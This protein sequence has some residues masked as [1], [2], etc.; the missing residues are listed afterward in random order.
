MRSTVFCKKSYTF[1]GEERSSFTQ[2]KAYP[3]QV[4]QSNHVNGFAII[5]DLGQTHW[6]RE[7]GHPEF[8]EYFE[9][10]N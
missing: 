4:T 7:P 9:M 2:G 10:L 8:D 6:I 3:V 1:P 5:N